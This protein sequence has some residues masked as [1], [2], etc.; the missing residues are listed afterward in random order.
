MGDGAGEGRGGSQR[1]LLL[2]QQLHGSQGA[3]RPRPAP[4][5]AQP[6]TQAALSPR[7]GVEH[8]P[9]AHR[10][11]CSS[12]PGDAHRQAAPQGTVLSPPPPS[13]SRQQRVIFGAIIRSRHRSKHFTYIDAFHPAHVRPGSA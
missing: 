1:S 11:A 5:Q 12:R 3:R 6:H 9:E 7:A 13:E 8:K 10:A 2:S 4:S